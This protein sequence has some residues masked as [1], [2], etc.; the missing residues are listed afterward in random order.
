MRCVEENNCDN[1]LVSNN[2]KEILECIA[3]RGTKALKILK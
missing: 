1:N 2:C 3:M